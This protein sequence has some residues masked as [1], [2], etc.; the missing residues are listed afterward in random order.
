MKIGEIYSRIN[1]KEN[2]NFKIYHPYSGIYHHKENDS[3]W[4]FVTEMKS[5]NQ[6]NYKDKLDGDI[7]EWQGQENQD[8]Y[9]I[10]VINHKK[11]GRKVHLLYREREKEYKNSAFRYEGEFTILS[12][13]RNNTNNYNLVEAV[14]VRKESEQEYTEEIEKEGGINLKELNDE[15]K[16]IEYKKAGNRK[17]RQGQQEFRKRLI[18]EYEKKCA[19]TSCDITIALEAIHIFGATSGKESMKTQNGLLLRVDI[20]RLYDEGLIAFDDD[21]CLILSKKLERGHYKKYNGKKIK[22]PKNENSY[23]SR[24][25]LKK[26]RKN[27]F[28]S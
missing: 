12:H 14:F 13:K 1:L 3:L 24:E 16:A 17:I 11:D 21:Y 15:A 7:L 27:K 9:N 2:F 18:K 6:T 23:P 8:F 19:V 20:H 25:L 4:L 22:L 10:R 5:E 26:H 28:I